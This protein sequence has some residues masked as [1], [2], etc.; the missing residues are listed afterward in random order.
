M[1]TEIKESHALIKCPHCGG[2]VRVRARTL[3]N[4]TVE[5]AIDETK[6]RSAFYK[7]FNE[8]FGDIFGRHWR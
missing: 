4:K 1:E 7:V 6:P 3:G 5:Q 2:Q 8:I